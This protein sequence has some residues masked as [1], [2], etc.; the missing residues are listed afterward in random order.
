MILKHADNLSQ[1][2]QSSTISAAEGQQVVGLSVAT[3]A[4]IK[5]DEQF[6]LFWESIKIKVLILEIS[7]PCLPRLT[8]APRRFEKRVGDSHYPATVEEHYRRH[9]FKI[10]DLAITVSSIKSQ[11]DIFSS[12]LSGMI[13]KQ[14]LTSLYEAESQKDDL[15]S[16][17][18]STQQT[19]TGKFTK[20]GSDAGQSSLLWSF[21]VK[22]TLY[23]QN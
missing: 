20:E 5:S 4:K 1:T 11:F 19:L 18:A 21:C 6:S 17:S 16:N 13:A 10:I 3:L 8:K 15:P 7:E 9:Y 14:I 2:L 23:I 22:L 12:T